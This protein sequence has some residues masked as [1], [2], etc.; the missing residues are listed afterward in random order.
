MDSVVLLLIL[1]P[2]IAASSLTFSGIFTKDTPFYYRRFPTFPSKLATLEYSVTFKLTNDHQYCKGCTVI[3]DIYTTEDDKNFQKHCSEEDFG[4]LRNE[5]LR[6]PLRPSQTSHRFTFCKL[7]VMDSDML[8]CTGWISIQDYTP[9]RYGFS[10]GYVCDVSGKPSL[11]GLRYNF[12]ITQ[13][14][15]KTQF[16]LAP[17]RLSGNVEKC[18]ALYNNISLP[19]MIGDHGI[20]SILRSSNLKIYDVFLSSQLPTTGCYKCVEEVI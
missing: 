18:L 17:Y 20:S 5:N 16:L 15:N 7:D 1:L 10:L 9:R 14:S 11:I 12:T 6:V 8:H 3:L 2:S 4:Q 13:Q 19:N